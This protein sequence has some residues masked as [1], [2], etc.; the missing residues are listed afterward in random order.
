MACP[1]V[2]GAA[3]LLWSA[4]PWL[5]GKVDMTEGFL[6]QNAVHISTSDCSSESSWPNNV[7]GYGRLDV[8][9]AVLAASTCEFDHPGDANGDFFVN[10]SD[11]RSVRDHFGESTTVYG[12]AN[13]DGFVNTSDYR[14]VRDN[15]GASY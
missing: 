15:F 3:A 4:R 8:Y 13:C 10:V 7:F 9:A 1:H 2:G 14:A 12:D 6:N 11:Y 5:R